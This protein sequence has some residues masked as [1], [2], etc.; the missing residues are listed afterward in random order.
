MKFL[1]SGPTRHLGLIG[2][3]I[4]HHMAFDHLLVIFNLFL[5]YV[6]EW[7]SYSDLTTCNRKLYLP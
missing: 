3:H 4:A 7:Y 5:S 1:G 6:H 2:F